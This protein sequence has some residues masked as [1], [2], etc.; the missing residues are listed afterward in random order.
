M[1]YFQKSAYRTAVRSQVSDVATATVLVY[2]NVKRMK[3]FG[4]H[5]FKFYDVLALGDPSPT[6]N[7][8]FVVLIRLHV[9]EPSDTMHPPFKSWRRPIASLVQSSWK[10]TIRS[11]IKSPIVSC[12][13]MDLL[14][15]RRSF[16][17]CASCLSSWLGS[18]YRTRATRRW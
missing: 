2:P 16:E 9:A 17:R 1:V 18:P 6:K 7:L 12:Y 14:S 11:V 5:Q 3:S 8:D 15:F 4:Q 13:I 10:Q